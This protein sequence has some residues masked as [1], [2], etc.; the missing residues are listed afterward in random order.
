M[1]RPAAAPW[2]ARNGTTALTALLL[3][4]AV[5]ERDQRMHQITWICVRINDVLDRLDSEAT[6]RR[7]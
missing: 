3:A 5:T 7:R 6:R 1:I 2:N 4:A